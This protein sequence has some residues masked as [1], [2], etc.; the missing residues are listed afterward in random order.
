MEERPVLVAVN[1]YRYRE[2]SPLKWKD[3][4]TTVCV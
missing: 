3:Y 1:D 4:N 2:P